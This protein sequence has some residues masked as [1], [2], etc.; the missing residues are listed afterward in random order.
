[1]TQQKLLTLGK[2][3]QFEN[4]LGTWWS[5]CFW[6]V[7]G[8][9]HLFTL[10]HQILRW[11]FPPS[12]LLVLLVFLLHSRVIQIRYSQTLKCYCVFFV[13]YFI[14]QP[15]FV[16]C[17]IL[18]FFFEK[19]RFFVRLKIC[20]LM[21]VVHCIHRECSRTYLVGLHSCNSIMKWYVIIICSLSEQNLTI[22]SRDTVWK[23]DET[24][25]F[26]YLFVLMQTCARWKQWIFGIM[27]QSSH[28]V[29]SPNH[30]TV[31]LKY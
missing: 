15:K 29:A 5:W 20:F 31:P 6:N 26:I 11:N 12:N 28:S 2:I 4:S 17:L 3:S 14:S 7:C 22:V 24:L 9:F 16:I 30:S 21:Q 25:C 27:K 23:L 8:N 19:F 1:M 13:L 18:G 10:V